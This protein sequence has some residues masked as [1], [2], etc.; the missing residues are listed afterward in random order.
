MPS[1]VGPFE[2]LE[3]VGSISY[4]LEL[5]PSLSKVHLLFHVS[6]IKRCHGDGEYIIKQNQFALIKISLLGRSQLWFLT[7][8]S[9]TWRWRKLN[10]WRFNRKIIQLKNLLVTTRGI[11][12]KYT[13]TYLRIHSFSSFF[14]TLFFLLDCSRTNDG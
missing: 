11:Y 3:D 14:L 5:P 6:M 1:Y 7:R 4:E 12:G 2:V 8:M 10:M 9:K 13:L